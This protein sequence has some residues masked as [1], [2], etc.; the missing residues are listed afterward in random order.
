MK[1]IVIGLLILLS[2]GAFFFSQGGITGNVTGEST[3]NLEQ[4]NFFAD[5][6]KQS[7]GITT[8]P[9]CNVILILIDTLRADH[10]GAYGYERN[11]T[12]NIDQLAKEGILFKNMLAQS[13]WT[14]PAT[15]SILTGLYPK[16]HGAKSGKDLLKEKVLLSEILQENGYTTAAFLANSAAGE[17]FGFNQ[18]YDLFIEDSDFPADWVNQKV[19]PHIRNLKNTSKNFIYVHYI[20]PHAPYNASE[21]HFSLENSNEFR[22]EFRKSGGKLDLDFFDRMREIEEKIE[23]QGLIPQMINLYDDE[24]LFNDKRAGEVFDALKEKDIYDNSI[25]III[26]DHG[27][28]FFEHHGIDHGST[29]FDEQLKVPWIMKV[30]GMKPRIIKKQVNQ[31][32]VMP[33]VL[34]IL[35]IGIKQIDGIDVFTQDVQESYA[36]LD[37]QGNN[38]DSIRTLDE[39]YIKGKVKDNNVWF[40]ETATIDVLALT[41]HIPIVSFLKDTAIQVEVDGRVQGLFDATPTKKDLVIDLTTVFSEIDLPKEVTL[42]A[43]EPC[44]KVA[45]DNGFTCLIF[46]VESGDTKGQTVP[47]HGYYQLRE[48]PKEKNNLFWI[49]ASQARLSNLNTELEKYL[50]KEKSEQEAVQH[51][52]EQLDVLR[53]LGYLN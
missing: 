41:T 14:E 9:D 18:G 50:A 20:D 13:S 4:Y 49:E 12:P 40:E 43:L 44:I 16:N 46:G 23:T 39:K 47:Y 28:E 27:E 31:I 25:I 29:L 38:L 21:E 1:K 19:V 48:D 3:E 17:V 36:E 10:M 6:F 5:P 26:S 24:I 15:A 32:D 34:A 30:P 42:T 51:T 33:T 22:E 37:W 35:G 7:Q 11:T 45:R 52:E 8:C 53:S 2:I